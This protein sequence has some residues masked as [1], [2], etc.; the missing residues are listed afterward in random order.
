MG[1][2]RA[3]PRPHV[4]PSGLPASLLLFVPCYLSP[5]LSKPRA[6]GFSCPAADR[7]SV[8]GRPPSACGGSQCSVTLPAVRSVT[9]GMAGGSGAHASACAGTGEEAMARNQTAPMTTDIAAGRQTG[10]RG[11]SPERNRRWFCKARP[12]DGPRWRANRR[13]QHTDTNPSHP[14]AGHSLARLVP[15]R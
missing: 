14:V 2:A 6:P 5:P 12:C 15:T 10:I 8:T 1:T 13:V 3:L 11:R 4:P 9:V 7:Y